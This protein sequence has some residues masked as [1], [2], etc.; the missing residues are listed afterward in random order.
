MGIFGIKLKLTTVVDKLFLNHQNVNVK[1]AKSITI[2]SSAKKHTPKNKKC[3]R[4]I[5]NGLVIRNK[6]TFWSG[7]K[8]LFQV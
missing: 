5:S 3:P 2:W 1:V 4:H 6:F 7:L 8:T